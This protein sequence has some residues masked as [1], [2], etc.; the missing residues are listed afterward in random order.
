MNG[1]GTTMG[2]ELSLGRPFGI[3]LTVNSWLAAFVGIVFGFALLTRQPLQGTWV[4]V[5]FLSILLH[6]WAHAL[7]ARAA[8]DTVLKITLHLLGG[9]TFR[10]GRGGPRWAWRITA[11]GPAVNVALAAGAW[12]AMYLGRNTLPWWGLALLA[13][14]FWANTI[15]A[16]FNLL[17]IFP[18]DG[19]QLARM[20]LSKRLGAGA[21]ARIALGLSLFTLLAVGI[22]FVASGNFHII[23]VVVLAQLFLLNVFEMRQ[24]G[25][26][27]IE[28]TRWAI[29][30]WWRER[31][32]LRDERAARRRDAQDSG[33]LEPSPFRRPERD[34]AERDAEILREG[35]R[36]LQKAVAAGLGALTPAE[37]RLLIL[38]RRLIEI[39][40]D[41]ARGTPD[42]EDLQMLEHH[43]RLGASSEV[44]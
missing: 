25:A 11:A 36:A 39:R 13:Q 3:P 29:G 35:R 2:R 23:A 21:G 1:A 40:I 38:H 42:P 44:H 24:T 31:R 14:T 41:T 30:Q 18:M 8:G 27:S 26:P 4:V 15:L 10:A 5:L 28:E 32:K 6:E 22:W 43:V 19:G 20:S 12:V 34:T 33:G 17:P 9:V 7:A 37:R 16:A